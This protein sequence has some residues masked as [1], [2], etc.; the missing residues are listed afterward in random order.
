MER[1]SAWGTEQLEEQRSRNPP[2][3]HQVARL[4]KGLW[5]KEWEKL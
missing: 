4:R 2:Y 5:E 1:L 3:Q